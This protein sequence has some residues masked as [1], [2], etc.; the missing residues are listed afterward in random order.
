MSNF[1]LSKFVT[2]KKHIRPSRHHVRSFKRL[3]SFIRRLLNGHATKF[4]CSYLL[5]DWGLT[6]TR[7]ELGSEF[8]S[9]GNHK[10]PERL[11]GQP[12]GTPIVVDSWGLYHGVDYFQGTIPRVLEWLAASM[13]HRRIPTWA[14]MSSTRKPWSPWWIA[15]ALSTSWR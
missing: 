9:A 7:A 15:K 8:S 12:C 6:S 13:F 5:K 3:T 1:I 10:T 4:R 14:V 2:K 11:Q